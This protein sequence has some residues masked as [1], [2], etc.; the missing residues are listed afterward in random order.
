MTL[1]FT[2]AARLLRTVT[3]SGAIAGAVVSFILYFAAGPGAF[4]ALIAVFLLAT[5]ATRF[6]YARKR[7]LGTAEKTGGRTASQVLAN[8]GVAAFAAGVFATFHVPVILAVMS[9]A[10]A[11][12]AADT[13][14][15][16]C[17]Q[18]VSSSA[19]LITNWKSVPAGT[20]GGITLAG[21]SAGVV[22]AFVIAA[23]CVL[24]GLISRTTA[25]AVWISGAF[26]MLFDSLLGGWLERRRVLNNDEVN[27][28][29]TVGAA[30][31]VLVLVRVFF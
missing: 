24:V 21:T 30:L 1:A 18:A 27:F 23:V 15:S 7:A 12:A 20:D 5:I 17:G 31:L 4:A 19:R 13:V 3:R 26:G 28:F 22:A 8:L 6:G 9:A 11:E 16:E 10:L 29:S 14:S 25:L 2:L